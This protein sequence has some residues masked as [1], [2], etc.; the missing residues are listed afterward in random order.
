MK[1]RQTYIVFVRDNTTGG[2]FIHTYAESAGQHHRAIEATRRKYAEPRY[3]V[4]TAYTLDELE[5]MTSTIRRWTAQPKRT[6]Q[7]AMP[8]FLQLAKA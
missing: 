6:E 4:H 8:D 7:L 5:N 2:E 1:Q 3:T